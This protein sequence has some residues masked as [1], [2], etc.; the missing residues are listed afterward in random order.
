MLPGSHLVGLAAAQLDPPD[1][2]GDRLGQLGELDP[3][4]PLVRRQ[5]LAGVPEDLAGQLPRRGVPRCEHDERLGHCQRTG[6]GDG[7]TAAS[8]TAGCSISTLS[9]SNGLIR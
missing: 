3:P 1:L 6:S 2:A 5:V 7:T 4:D 8:A 9:S